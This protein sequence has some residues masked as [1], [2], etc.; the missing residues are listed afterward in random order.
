MQIDPW[1]RLDRPT[2]ARFAGAIRSFDRSE[3][4]GR[5]RVRF[6]A[7]VVLLLCINGLNVVNSYVG[8]D[9]MTAI[10]QR[11]ASAFFRQALLYV[12][13]F[14]ASTL[15]A[16]IYRATEERL[17]LLWREWLTRRLV[18]SYTEH[19]TY[20]RLNDRLLANGEI[21]NP[22]QRIADDVRAFTTTTLSF[23]LLF[24][25]ASLTVFAFSGVMWS[26]SPLLFL[27]GVGY[28]AVGS[29][30]A[31]A[32]GHPLVGLNY[33]QLDKEASFR[34]ELLHVQENAESLALSHNE[35]HLQGRLMRMIDDLAGNLRRIIAVNRNLGFFTT[36]YNYMIQIIPALIVAPM[37]IRS[38][39]EFGVITQSAMAFSQLLG[40]FSIIVTQFQSISS[41]TAV[42]ARLGSFA[43]AIEQAQS[44]GVAT[45][46]CSIPSRSEPDC[47]ICLPEL[48]AVEGGL[49]IRIRE[50]EAGILYE[51]LTLRSTQDRR[52]L[53]K[54]LTA[55]VLPGRRLLVTGANHAAKL[56]L[57]RATA[58]I[59]DVGEGSI[60]RP[61][62]QRLMFLPERPYLPRGTLRELL[63]GSGREQ[64]HDDGW[65]ENA[66]SRFALE[67][68]LSRGGGLDTEQDWDHLR[69]LGEQQLI[70]LARIFLAAPQFVF[71]DRP[72]TIL[73]VEQVDRVLQTLS[74]HSITYLTIG[75][76]GALDRRHDA[77]LDVEEDGSWRWAEPAREGRDLS[78]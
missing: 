54:D 40:A 70:A 50:D 41:F 64:A 1:P 34:A 19:P 14:A 55:S 23:V 38:Q 47:P 5:A 48:S 25:N 44:V 65:I 35:A 77:V 72:T 24:L 7:L 63:A 13:V 21:A 28:A 46:V 31:I 57:F 67:A 6:L 52:L 20:Y 8:R 26:I 10:E 56:A 60:V 16:V 71:L 18:A 15:A 17:A 66:L 9:F 4:G 59:W 42:V 78:I 3:V 36:G 51:N 43:E 32:F 68:V 61:G 73:G 75:E 76:S 27:V 39:A 29:F 69:S 45:E 58:G 2:W 37:F 33:A 49:A 22:D 74:E 30:V 62:F 11:S 53:I 12:A